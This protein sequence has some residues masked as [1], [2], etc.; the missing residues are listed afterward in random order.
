EAERPFDLGRAPLLRALLFRLGEGEHALF[1]NQHHVVTD[2]WSLGLLVAEL[3]AAEAALRAGRPPL[4]PP[5]PIQYADFAAW[6]REQLQGETLERKLAPWRRRLAGAPAELPFPPDHPHRRT[7]DAGGLLRVALPPAPTARLA[8]LARDSGATLFMALL[9]TF[10]ALLFRHGGRTDLVVGSPVSG[11]GRVETEGVIGCFVNTLALRVR[12]EGALSFRELL[13][14]VREVVVEAFAGDDLPFEKLVEEICPERRLRENP[15]FQVAFGFLQPPARGAE[16]SG[17]HL[18]LIEIHSGTSKFDLSLS[19][20]E[21]PAGIA[22]FW[23]Y[24]AARFDPAT[25]S[26]LSLHWLTLLTDAA[27]RPD[28]PL[29][30]L[31]LLGAAER[32]QLA[33]E[34]NDTRAGYPRKA[35]IPALFAA[36]AACDPAA[37]ALVSATGTV[38]Y[39]ELAARSRR[40]ARRLRDRGI[41]PDDLVGVFLERGPEMVT[42]WLAALEAGGAYLPLDPDYPAERL[43]FMLADGRVRVLVTRRELAARFPAGGAAVVLIEEMEGIADDEPA[44]ANGATPESLAYVVYTSGSTGTPKGVAVPQRAVVRLVRDSDYARLTAADRIAQASNASFDAA[45]FEVWGA[46]LNGGC[47][48]AFERD[49]TLSPEDLAREIRRRGITAL[50]LTTA[51]FNRIASLAPD[52]FAGVR[53]LLFGGEAV[54]PSRVAEVLASGP[55]ERLLHV[56]GPTE[57]ATFTTWQRVRAVAPGAGTIPIGRP[58]ANTTVT[59]LDAD[60]R[61]VPIGVAGELYLGGDGLARGYFARPDLTAERFVPRPLSLGEDDAPG[62]RLYRTGDLARLLP[63][64]AVEFVGR[65]DAQVKIRGFRVEPAEVEAALAGH[66]ALGEAAVAPRR[67]AGGDL[68]LVAWFVPRRTPSPTPRELRDFLAARLP[69]PMLPAAFVEVAALPRTPNGKVDRAALPDPEA[70]TAT[71]GWEPPRTAVEEVLAG[72][73]ADVLRIA[74]PRRVGARDNFFDLGGHSLTATAMTS[75]ARS[76]FRVELP[77]RALFERPTLA[78]LAEHVETLLAAG[79][80]VELPPIAPEPR[81]GDPPLSFAQQRLWFLDELSGGES[82]FYNIAA[83]LSLAGR[84]DV[85][86]LERALDAIM[87]R[88]ES[89]RTTFRGGPEGK[90]V[91]VIHPHRPFRVPV[92]DLRS[93]PPAARVAEALRQAHSGVARPFSL[94]R[95]PLFRVE[96]LRVEDEQHVLLLSMHHIVSDGWSLDVLVRELVALYVAFA[97]GHPSPLPALPVQYADFALWQRRWLGG[98]PLDGQLAY[99]RRQLAGA[100]PVFELAADRPRPAVQTYDGGTVKVQLPASLAERLQGLARAHRVTLFMALLAAFASLLERHTRR[101]DILLGTPIANRNRAETAGLIGFFVNM[102]VLRIDLSGDPGFDRLLA[103]VRE[104]ALGAYAHQDLPFE[105]LVEELQPARDLSRPPIFQVC[106]A[107]A[108]VPWHALDLPGL[109]LGFLDAGATV[110]LYDLTLQITDTGQGL[111]VRLSYNADLFDAATIE[112]LGGHLEIL[113]DALA[114]DPRRAAAEVEI[115]SGEERRQLLADW[116]GARPALAPAALVHALFEA[117]ARLRPAAPALVWK[118]G[119]ISYEELDRRANRLAHHLL[120]LGL[121]REGIVALHLEETLDFAAAALGVWKAGGAFLPLDPRWPRER[122]TWALKDSQA[123]ALVT[124]GQEKADQR[125]QGQQGQQG[126]ENFPDVPAVP[127]VPSVPAVIDLDAARE[128]IARES[129]QAPGREVDPGQLAYVIYTSGSTGEPKGVEVGHQAFSLHAQEM[130]RLAAIGPGDRLLQASSFAADMSLEQV[131]PPLLAG[132]AVLP[133]H[134][135]VAG[136]PE[137][138]RDLRGSGVTMIDLPTALWHQAATEWAQGHSRPDLP[139]LRWAF[140]GG[141]AIPP[142]ALALWRRTPL[143]HVPLING[144]GPTEATVTTAL[145]IAAPDQHDPR[146][147]SRLPIGRPVAP[148]A[149]YLLDDRGGL[150]PPG[151][152]G[153]LC[154]GGPALA[155]GYL[156]RPEATAAAFVPDPFGGVPGARLYRTGDLA[157]FLADGNLDFQGRRDAQMKLLGYRI[158]PGEIET[159]LARHPE[160]RAAAVAVVAGGDAADP[161]RRTL[162]AWVVSAPGA[163]PSTSGLRAFLQEKLPPHMVPASFTVTSE[164]PLTTSGKVDRDALARSGPRPQAVEALEAPAGPGDAEGRSAEIETQVIALWKEVLGID[165]VGPD[166]NFFDLGGHSMLVAWVRASIQ[167]TFGIDLEMV[168]LFNYPTARALAGRLLQDLR[169]APAPEVVAEPPMALVAS[170]VVAEPAAA[171]ALQPAPAIAIVGMAGR[172]PGACDV[173]A[174]WRN[175]RDG[176]ESISFFETD[177]TPPEG[178]FYRVPA[179]GL[180]E[181][182]DLFDAAFFGYSPREAELMDPQ[183]RLFL[184]CAWEAL[185]NAGHTPEGFAGAIGVFGGASKNDY[186]ARLFDAGV[187]REPVGS[188]LSSLGNDRDNLTLRVSYKLDLEGPSLN[189][190]TTCSTSLVAVHLAAMSLLAGECDM[191][192]AGGVSVGGNSRDGYFYRP[193]DV[194]S[195]DG[196]CRAFDA[197][198]AGSVDADGVAIVVL[199]RLADALAAG[200][201]VHAVL[202]GTGINNDGAGKVGFMAPRMAS[203]SRLVRTVL[204]R[205]GVPADT[206]TYVEAHGTATALGDPIEVAALTAAFRAGT[207]RTGFCA[208]GSLKT[209]IGHTNSASG[210]AGLIKATLALE[211]RQIPPTLHYE[212]PNPEIDFAASPFFVNTRLLDWDVP[213]GTPRRAAIN[214]FGV[215]GTNAHVVLEEAPA[216]P[217]RPE[218]A[219]WRLLTLSARSGAALDVATANLA[220]HLER[221]PG[222]PLDDVAFTLQTGRRAFDHRRAVLCRDLDE[223]TAALGLLDAG[224]TATG[225][226]SRRAAAVFLFPGQGAQTPGAGTG[227][228]AAEPLFKAEI[229][230]CA[231]LLLPH[232]GRD[233][234]DVLFQAEAIGADRTELAQPALFTLEWALARTWMAWGV[235]PQAMLGHSLGEYVAAT[236]AGVFSLPDAL[237]LVTARGRLIQSLPGGAM[238]AVP[239]PAAELEPLLDSGLALA[240]INGP[241]RCVL[242]GPGEAIA[243]LQDR[244]ARRGVAGRRLAVSHAFHSSMMDSILPAFAAELG[245]LELRPPAIPFLSNLTGRW[246]Q[247]AEATDPDYWVRH[248]RGTVRFAE[249]MAELLDDPARVF[250]EVGPGRTLTGFAQNSARQSRVGQASVTVFPSLPQPAE[251]ALPEPAYALFTLGRLWTEG[252]AVDWPSL[253]AGAD[254]RRVPLPTYPFERKRFWV[255]M[256]QESPAVA[257]AAVEPRRTDDP[258]DWFYVPFWRPALPVGAGEGPAGL[259]LLFPDAHGLGRRLERSL[260]DAGTEVITV[261]PGPGFGRAG[262]RSYRLRP[263][264]SEDYDAL[265]ADLKGRGRLPAEVV[266]LWNVGSS[267]D[268]G[269]ARTAAFDS[270]MLLAQ[271]L[272]REASRPIRVVLVS[273]GLHAVTGREAIQPEKALLLGPSRSMPQRFPGLACRAVDVELP[274]AE[275]AMDELVRQLA[276]ELASAGDDAVVAYRDRRRWVQDFAPQRL[277]AA[278]AVDRFRPEGVYL[279]T[280]GMGGIGSTLLNVL[281]ERCRARLV[282]IGRSVPPTAGAREEWLSTH[283]DDDPLSRRLRRLRSLEARGAEILALPADVTDPAAMRE[284]RRRVEER[285][286]AVHGIIHAAGAAGPAM[287][288]WSRPEAASEAFAAK[289]GGTLALAEAF[290]GAPLDLFV[291]CSSLSSLLGGMGQVGYAASNAFLDAFAW[292]RSADPRT[293]T[294]SID[295]D[296]W[297]EVGFEAESQGEHQNRRRAASGLTSR[298]GAVVFQHALGYGFPQVAVSQT[299]VRQL[300]AA[301]RSWETS[302]F[303]A[304]RR[305]EEAPIPPAAPATTETSPTDDVEAAIAAVWRELLGVREVGPQDNF[306]ALGGDSLIALGLTARLHDRFRVALSPGHVYAAATLAELAGVVRGLQA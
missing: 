254:R 64:G 289:V 252:I 237:A 264:R 236:L 135:E 251:T 145:Y 170:V 200:D 152:V 178:G 220:L 171:P 209:N 240:A 175:L 239:L 61:P 24:A 79:L 51:L 2:A 18:D 132:A 89:L 241:S 304:A 6:Q 32:H 150:V 9:A 165:E 77:T 63:D 285:F 116:S 301:S 74:P 272:A 128:A 126:Q 217:P 160:V 238:L 68:A 44:P 263:G 40:L 233:V 133:W 144:Y 52:A 228:Y 201:H 174:L 124:R 39:G 227:L 302:G 166:D 222:L 20:T 137:L 202:K 93:L 259:R 218:T 198:A 269:S 86:V 196:H 72:L 181:G 172:F 1:L 232:L 293:L 214:S 187:L 223:A 92:A 294:M 67:Q 173:D 36:Q 110:E 106:F 127:G 205:A 286:G 297:R 122:L 212:A 192:L 288:D 30:A 98:A 242:S 38:T 195:P 60:L 141:E 104:T 56:Y 80:G 28:E 164:L 57:G 179:H 7:D 270:P 176:V 95:G 274:A 169:A 42:A 197:R 284:V 226:A 73:W 158:E 276:G 134:P 295:W 256:P 216:P 138:V 189:V 75:L 282:V 130:A 245:K 303:R 157:R 230:R 243:A 101:R 277:E 49:V 62:E 265:V 278:G 185:E 15:L 231:E 5:L 23:E 81:A 85:H 180:L 143:A 12:L 257:P 298:Q 53:H 162:A 45:T 25:L 102:L 46:L 35:T 119:E 97:A 121:E 296:L 300:M 8:A 100:P 290:R 16:G 103:R 207:D 247:A 275:S 19:L 4:L 219:G 186:L 108:S 183:Q 114:E 271:A 66:P 113:L 210:V 94:T 99:W 258:A 14:R 65:V 268:L 22:G 215:G 109:T 83:P 234:R 54:D 146:V 115:L 267:A 283:P 13:G 10:Q 199:K 155:R 87:G 161:N 27:E 244:L 31:A 90:P 142:D 84:L 129:S 260:L 291:L 139:A 26:R 287:I 159:V 213:A 246:I 177:W 88:H 33:V 163:A 292:S 37:P 281:W 273:T 190:Q 191:A 58:L 118:G 47:L 224:R 211:H 305:D 111:D 280:G 96:L 194:L 235:T 112:R 279:V 299:D 105:R 131:F 11:R 107:M 204:D 206:V 136:V 140:T 221:H 71:A 167:E 17:V 48:V 120:A 253:H 149:V 70:A 21:S 69:E 156:G 91:Q 76:T 147:L 55:P 184:E 117:Q 229:D 306:F 182:A 208:L 43:A 34:W 78:E 153:E 168:E 148:H 266:H 248:L 249:G 262:E 50:F 261:V 123:Q 225:L 59:L 82:P 41:G 3:L 151:A 188:Q 193:G 203:Q 154:V 255:E 125:R 29:A 250:L